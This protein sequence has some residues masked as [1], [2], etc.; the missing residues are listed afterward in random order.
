M[1]QESLRIALKDFLPD[2]LQSDVPLE[3]LERE[4]VISYAKL[5]EYLDNAET[6][7]QVTKTWQGLQPS[8]IRIRRRESTPSE[9]I[10][11]DD[12]RRF[13]QAELAAETL[14]D[15]ADEDWKP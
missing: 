3:A 9:S 2:F 1:L 5:A 10:A 14:A 12:E 13:E 11:S 8:K 6:R 4:I 7:Y 15:E